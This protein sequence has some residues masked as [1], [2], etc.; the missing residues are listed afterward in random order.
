MFGDLRLPRNG[1][2]IKCNPQSLAIVLRTFRKTTLL[3]EVHCFF[4]SLHSKRK[5]RQ[6]KQN[7]VTRV[8][9]RGKR[10]I[11]HMGAGKNEASK[12]FCYGFFVYSIFS[13][14]HCSSFIFSL[15]FCFV[16]FRNLFRNLD[17]HRRL[18]LKLAW[19]LQRFHSLSLPA[20]CR[21]NLQRSSLSYW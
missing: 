21:K 3:Y 15:N 1:L 19:T 17:H 11:M 2:R 12:D 9:G 7:I 18:R 14:F 16:F 13:S 20:G 6:R 8:G 5:A 10:I 4:L